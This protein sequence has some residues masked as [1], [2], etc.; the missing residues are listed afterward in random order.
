MG[1]IGGKQAEELLMEAKKRSNPATDR[2]IRAAL[3]DLGEPCIA[4]QL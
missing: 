1:A 4:R 2:A 3:R